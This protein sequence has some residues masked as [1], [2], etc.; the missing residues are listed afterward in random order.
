M[1]LLSIF[2]KTKKQE[3]KNR[4]ETR[5]KFAARIVGQIRRTIGGERRALFEHNKT[6]MHVSRTD[7]AELLSREKQTNRR[8]IWSVDISTW[9]R[10]DAR[11]IQDLITRDLRRIFGNTLPL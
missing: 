10:D 2:Q 7:K 8:V 4:K 11:Y 9:R 1:C 6:E 3:K 5:K